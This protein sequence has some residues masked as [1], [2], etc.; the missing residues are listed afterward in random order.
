MAVAMMNSVRFM[1]SVARALVLVAVTGRRV[2]AVAVAASVRSGR[3]GIGRR[4][5]FFGQDAAEFNAPIR[6]APVFGAVV[7]DRLAFAIAAR[8]R[9]PVSIR[10]ASRAS[11]TAS[12][13]LWLSAW[14][15][16]SRPWLSV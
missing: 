9:L 12:A 4:L 6:L 16:S 10:R 5:F 3:R 8:D 14:F 13:R 7:G 15:I 1:P 2:R 11:I